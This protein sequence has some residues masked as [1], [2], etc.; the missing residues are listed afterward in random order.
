MIGSHRDIR[1]VVASALALKSTLN[2]QSA[3]RIAE[4]VISSHFQWPPSCW[5]YNFRFE[6]L[7][8]LQVA[9]DLLRLTKLDR[10]VNAPKLVED[11]EALVPE[12]AGNRA[13]LFGP[14]DL[15]HSHHQTNVVWQDALPTKVLPRAHLDWWYLELPSVLVSFRCVSYCLCC[16]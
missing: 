10:F 15:L 5:D 7:N 16:V 6:T 3:K 2:F 4:T 14:N 11:V 9:T 12:V 1:G 13:L 8:K